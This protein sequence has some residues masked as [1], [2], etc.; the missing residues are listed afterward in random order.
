[1]PASVDRCSPIDSTKEPSLCVTQK[2]RPLV[3]SPCVVPCV[4][5]ACWKG[6]CMSEYS[7]I[8]LGSCASFSSSVGRTAAA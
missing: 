6:I 3:L 1:M 7:L 5:T 2:N 8:R 4:V